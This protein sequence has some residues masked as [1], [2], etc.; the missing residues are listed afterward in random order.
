MLS[1][2][3]LPTLR[4]ISSSP[5]NWVKVTCHSLESNL[6]ELVL[7]GEGTLCQCTVGPTKHGKNW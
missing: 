4:S 2:L 1:A 5:R 3:I 7:S 6:A